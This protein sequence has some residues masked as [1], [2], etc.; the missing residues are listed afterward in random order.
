MGN[1]AEKKHKERVDQE[2]CLFVLTLVAQQDFIGLNL[3]RNIRGPYNALWGG[4]TES[5]YPSCHHT[6][7]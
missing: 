2:N 3:S 6:A 7:F 4:T 5:G 1:A